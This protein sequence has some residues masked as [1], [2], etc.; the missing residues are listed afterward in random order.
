MRGRAAAPKIGIFEEGTHRVVD[1]P[2]CLVH[3]PLVNGAAAELR[4]AIV[5]TRSPPYSDAAHAG[6][7]RYAQIVVER[8]TQT[9]QVVLVTNSDDPGAAAPLFAAFADR[10][11]RRLQGLFWNGNRERTNTILGPRFEKLRG[12]DAVEERIGG[13]RVFYPPGAFGQSHLDLADRIVDT[14]H[15]WVPDGSRVLELYA[16]VGP[17]GLGLVPRAGHV[18]FN[19]ASEASLEGLRLGLSAL[20]EA[21]RRRTSVAPGAAVGAAAAIRDAD[22]VIA[23]PPR[24]GLDPEVRAALLAAPPRSFLYV[25]CG[26]SAFLEDTRG[27][28]GSGRFGLAELVAF[29]L[30]PYTEHVEVAARFERRA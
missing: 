6:L 15:G 3:H 27:L 1:I 14:V 8:P 11:G 20:G 21:D 28:V 7:L 17:I 19:E 29:D 18:A 9:A 22:V 25:A 26:L 5:A 10:F 16:G 13:A 24:K 12:G 23:D 2:R 4:R 30:F